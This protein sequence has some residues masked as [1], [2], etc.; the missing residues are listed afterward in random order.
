MEIEAMPKNIATAI[1]NV[2]TTLNKPLNKDAKNDYQNYSYTSIDGFLKEVQPAC[3]KAGLIII[4]HEKSCEVSQTGKSLSVVYEYILI[5]KEG[6]TWNFPTTKHIIVPF[7][8]GTAMG[9]A[10][11]YALKQF[12]RSLFQLSTGEKDDLDALDQDKIKKNNKPKEFSDD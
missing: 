8:S 3:A 6:D 1:N 4:P 11:S 2:M 12:M 5:H 9:T 10:Q 7:G